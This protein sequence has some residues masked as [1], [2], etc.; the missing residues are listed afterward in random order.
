MDKPPIHGAWVLAPL[1]I[2]ALGACGQAA[3]S[4]SSAK[5]APGGD[6][7][8][9]EWIAGSGSE[10][11]C[12]PQR[13]ARVN[14]PASELYMIRGKAQYSPT[15]GGPNTNLPLQIQFVAYDEQGLSEDRATTLVKGEAGCGDVNVRWIIS[16]CV[17]TFESSKG[18]GCPEIIVQG[19]EAFAS[20][21]LERRDRD[22]R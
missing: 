22:P 20:F 5:E 15:A 4:V 1:L 13:V 17:Y 2:A 16:E 6:A 7:V 11:Q 12:Q 9:I 8:Q 19:Q 18:P 14:V 21:N 10:G 3:E